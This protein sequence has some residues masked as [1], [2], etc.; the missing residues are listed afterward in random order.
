MSRERPPHGLLMFFGAMVII[1][2]A[3]FGAAAWELG[4]DI[5]N[6]PVLYARLVG[7]IVGFVGGSYAVGYAA[8]RKGVISR[9]E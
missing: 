6:R 8:W 1:M 5:V 9:A 4:K 7:V 2:L 3:L